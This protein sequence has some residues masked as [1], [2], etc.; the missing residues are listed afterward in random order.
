MD[1]QSKIN[2]LQSINKNPYNNTFRPTHS[3]LELLQ[4]SHDQTSVFKIAGRIFLKRHLGKLCFAKIRDI[5]GEIQ[6]SFTEKT[7]GIDTYSEYMKLIDLG[8]ILGII[9]SIYTTNSGELTLQVIAAEITAK[10]LIALPDKYHGLQNKEVI[11]RQ[12]YLDLII[13]RHSMSV[14]KARC[15]IIQCVRRFFEDLDFIEVETPMLH[16][17]EDCS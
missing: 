17:L 7:L 10:T 12:R 8:D 2:Y 9:G 6:I 15:A 14:F 3:V 11:Y 1:H 5:T 13:N 16:S 4:Q